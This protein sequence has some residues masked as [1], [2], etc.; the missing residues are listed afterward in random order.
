MSTFDRYA[1]FIQDFIYEHDWQSL[2]SVQV[3][4]AVGVDLHGLRAGGRHPAGVV[5]GLQ[6]ALDDRHAELPGQIAQGAL[7]Q[8]GFSRA[9][10]ADQIERQNFAAAQLPPHMGGHFFIGFQDVAHHGN[11]HVF[12]L[13]SPALLSGRVTTL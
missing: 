5:V 1:P 8:R 4:A 12:L 7:Q 9:G 2:R 10:R 11:L 6:V 3:A 13:P